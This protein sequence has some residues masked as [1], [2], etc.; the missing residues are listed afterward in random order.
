MTESDDMRTKRI[1]SDTLSLC[2][3]LLTD[4]D[5]QEISDFIENNEYELA[6]ETLCFALVEDKA[7]PPM[8][9][10]SLLR[11][12]PFIDEMRPGLL[13]EVENLVANV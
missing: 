9:L 2:R 4:N 7:S 1:I 3:D 8:T 12:L 6:A 5:V 11:A 13:E 10:M